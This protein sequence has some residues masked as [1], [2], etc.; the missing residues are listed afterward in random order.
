M[1][2]DEWA[3]RKPDKDRSWQDDVNYQGYADPDKTNEIEREKEEQR[4]PERPE[5]RERKERRTY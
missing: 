4:E 5:E 3:D 2:M 1:V